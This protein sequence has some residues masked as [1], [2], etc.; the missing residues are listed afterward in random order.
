MNY[1]KLGHTDIDVS[2]V[3]L[4][5]WA[6][7]GWKWGG[8]DE[9]DAIAAIRTGIDE[10]INLVDT[11]PAYGFGLAEE[12]I[13]KAIVGR[14]DKVVLASK[15]GLVWHT[16]RGEHFF[17]AEGHQ[18]HRFLGSESIRYELEQSLKR[19]KVDCIDLYQTHWQDATTAIDDTMACLE[20]LKDQGKIRAIGVSNCTVGQLEQYEAAGQL[21]VDQEEYNM[22]DRKHEDDLLPWCREHGTSVLA[23]SAMALGLLTGK[24]TLDRTFDEGDMRKGSPRFNQQ[25]RQRVLDFCEVIR[26]VADA[27]NATIAQTVIAWTTAQPG[28]TVALCG[29]RNPKQATENAAAGAIELTDTE[30]KAINE[31]IVRHL[32]DIP[33]AW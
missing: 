26:P 10:G 18:V 8:T 13:G 3:G 14:R 21:D 29:A 33:K 6:I 16:D 31:S 1:R 19:M 2:V 5:T 9:T 28:V 12:L 15:C 32:D 30:L 17:E 4:G 24:V 23:Y 25:N 27:H 11:A 22:I 7:G 20:K